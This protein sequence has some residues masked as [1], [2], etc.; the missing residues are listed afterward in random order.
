MELPFSRVWFEPDSFDQVLPS[1]VS[2]P[3]LFKGDA[4]CVVGF[5]RL[6]MAF[7]S[8]AADDDCFVDPLTLQQSRTIVKAASESGA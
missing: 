8:P 5:G 7:V 2:L 4:E 6:E 1:F 3:S